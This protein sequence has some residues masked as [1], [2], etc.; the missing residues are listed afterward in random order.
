MISRVF[1]VLGCLAAAGWIAFYLYVNSLACAFS[2]PSG[3]QNCG[4]T[5]PW[6]LQGEDLVFLVL[7]PGGLVALLFLVARL[8]RHSPPT[9]YRMSAGKNALSLLGTVRAGAARGYEPAMT[10]AL[11]AF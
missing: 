3:S 1:C 8:T 11:K 4:V 10:M 7:I 2:G 6:Q 5:P 9:P